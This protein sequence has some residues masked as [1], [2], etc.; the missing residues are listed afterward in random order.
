MTDLAMFIIRVAHGALLAGHGAQKLFGSFGGFGLKGTAGWLESIGMR[1]GKTW[2]TLAGISE[3]GGGVLTA[4][5][6]L[7]PIGPLMGLG[8]MI[9]ASVKVHAG[10]PIWVSSGGAELPVTNIAIQVAL[11]LAGPGR[12]SIDRLLGIRLPRLVVLPALAA[13]AASVAYATREEP[14]PDEAE[15]EGGMELQAGGDEPLL[16]SAARGTPGAGSRDDPAEAARE[17]IDTL[18]SSAQA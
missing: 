7:N 12:L 15:T 3:F 11:I 18:A 14:A 9:M 6:F 4:L 5:G 17:D 13:I 2:A 1:P 8:S 16:G 10:K